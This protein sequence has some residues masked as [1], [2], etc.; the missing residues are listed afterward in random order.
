MSIQKLVK[1]TYNVW[2]FLG[3]GMI[4]TVNKIRNNIK[5][6]RFLS[7]CWPVINDKSFQKY[8]LWIS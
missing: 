8:L 2:N 3:H 6:W 1:S 5:I 7:Y 4:N